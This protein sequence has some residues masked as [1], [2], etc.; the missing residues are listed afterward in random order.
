MKQNRSSISASV[1]KNIA[2][3]S[4]LID[5]YFAVVFYKQINWMAAQGNQIFGANII[6]RVGR[7][8]GKSAFILFAFMAAEGFIHT[9]SRTKYL[10]RLFLFALLSE[11][12][13]DLAISGSM[14]SFAKQN[15]YFTLFLGVLALCLMEYAKGHPVLQALSVL[16]CGISALLLHTDYAIMGVFLVVTFYLCRKDFVLQ[17]VVGSFVIYFGIILVDVYQ[18][19]DHGY[20]LMQYMTFGLRELYGLAAFLPIYFYNGKKGRQLPR[21]C[22]YMFYPVHLFIL[23]RIGQLFML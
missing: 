21:L 14:A 17:F 20:S 10:L 6:Y 8:V 22:Y 5:H 15:V 1:L 18:N 7:S 4:M 16:A 23:Y 19:W 12:S 13:F 11:I 9:R 2:Y 3:L